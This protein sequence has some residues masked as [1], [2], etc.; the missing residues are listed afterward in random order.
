MTSSIIQTNKKCIVEGCGSVFDLHLH[1][2][3]FG[4]NRQKSDD[5]G[6]VVWLCYDHHEGTKGVHGRDGHELDVKL[7]KL[8]EAQWC[9]YYNKTIKDFIK[10]Y[11]RNYL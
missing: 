1:H 7:K 4:K 6:L 3:F 5:D 11:G 10:R 8:A 9:S 2:V